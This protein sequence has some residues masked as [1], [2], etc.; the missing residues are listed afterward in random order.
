M[1][2][3]IKRLLLY[4]ETNGLSKEAL[5]DGAEIGVSEIDSLL[6]GE[7]VDEPTARKLIY[8]L[9][10]DTAQGLIDWNAIGK[11]N[12]LACKADNENKGG[13]DE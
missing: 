11:V 8:Y 7:A 4:L 5:A 6:N 13:N 9:G 12:P 10:A 2:V 3:K 1:K